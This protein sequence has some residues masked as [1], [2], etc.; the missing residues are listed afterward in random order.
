MEKIVSPSEVSYGDQVVINRHTY[1]VK[2]T[3]GPDNI[4]TYDFYVI[5]EKGRDHLEIVNGAVTLLV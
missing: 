5:D 2:S 4:G 1:T 3:F